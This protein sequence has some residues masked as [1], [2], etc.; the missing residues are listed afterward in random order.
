L[1]EYYSDKKTATDYSFVTGEVDEITKKIRG[2]KILLVEQ[3]GK[4]YRNEVCISV[5]QSYLTNCRE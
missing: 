1:T 2:T 4:S 5:S 3:N